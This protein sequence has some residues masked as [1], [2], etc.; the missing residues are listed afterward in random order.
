MKPKSIIIISVVGVICIAILTGVSFL[1]P[2][3][4]PPEEKQ[5]NSSK[6][7]ELSLNEKIQATENLST[8]YL[9]PYRITGVS[10][11][12]DKG[13][14]G[15]GIKIAV[16]DS[17][18]DKNHPDL[19]GKIIKE[20]D[21]VIGPEFIYEGDIKKGEIDTY[22]LTLIEA[23]NFLVKLHC[24]ECCNPE[25]PNSL[26]LKIMST[27]NKTICFADNPMCNQKYQYEC[28]INETINNNL[29]I[30]IKGKSISQE[31]ESVGYL[32]E[33]YFESTYDYYGHGTYSAGICA[34]SGKLSNGTYKGIAPGALLLNARAFTNRNNVK[35]SYVV[36]AIKWAIENNADIINLNIG[37]DPQPNCEEDQISEIIKTAI[38]KGIIVVAAGG[39]EKSFGTITSPGCLDEVITVGTAYVDGFVV[40]FGSSK[41][42]TAEGYI[43]PD[44]VAPGFDIPSTA[45]GGEYSEGIGTSV[46][47]S[48]VS[49]AVALLLQ[50]YIKYH[51]KKPE[52][53]LI[54]SILQASAWEPK[55][56]CPNENGAG[57]INLSK[58]YRLMDNCSMVIP[59]S[60]EF[61][62]VY[63][64][65]TITKMIT[66][67]NNK[68]SSTSIIIGTDLFNCC[69]NQYPNGNITSWIQ[70]PTTV[71][72]LPGEQKNLTVNITVPF[73]QSS[74]IY[75][76]RISIE[77]SDGCLN[78]YLSISVNV[79][80]NTFTNEASILSGEINKND[81]IF[82]TINITPDT[83][84][85]NV[86]LD[87][88]N[89]KNLP[90]IL[91]CL[92][93]KCIPSNFG[94]PQ[95]II[96]ENPDPEIYRL[97]IGGSNAKDNYTLTILT[98]NVTMLNLTKFE[99]V[100][101]ATRLKKIIKGNDI[102]FITNVINYHM[103][104]LTGNCGVEIEYKEDYGYK[105]IIS[106][107]WSG[108]IPAKKSAIMKNN[109]N[110]SA[111][112]AGVY[113]AVLVCNFKDEYSKN[114]ENIIKTLNFEVR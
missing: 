44:I 67:Q 42:P 101:K 56:Y 12:W 9:N 96:L 70:L 32:M 61:G 80:K 112:G 81:N 47:S 97:W 76:G 52:P 10:E 33:I 71:T 8:D 16:I 74:G 63:P 99:V 100:D 65:E 94:K 91:L 87:W 59:A 85:L 6:K 83:K 75:T 27:D 29:T 105:Y 37:F 2:I 102:S 62:Y 54:K 110:T 46:S 39:D 43:K 104:N 35:K 73:N 82:Y 4:E 109:I 11:L 30:K 111:W 106:W 38:N 5:N 1:K 107:M 41:G 90:F 7:T 77:S 66:I 68:N 48:Y 84:Q 20:K 58:A 49:G 86:T 18:I 28:K 69:I 31:Y 34:G 103:F 60:I 14:T 89:T 88:S 53:I 19:K 93:N 78:G 50:A 45:P 25:N 64:N 26:E 95:T 114:E 24:L 21:F 3:N 17:G 13:Y 22:N 92:K 55:E 98:A 113:R 40:P 15:S 51:G 23:S 108:N 72:L 79:V 36:E 57:F